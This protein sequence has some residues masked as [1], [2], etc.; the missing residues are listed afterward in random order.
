MQ[1]RC[2]QQLLEADAA[3][4]AAAAAGIPRQRGG[5]R[6]AVEEFRRDRQ[7]LRRRRVHLDHAARGPHQ[8]LA[9][10]ARRLLVGAWRCA[11]APAWSPPTSACRSRGWPI[12][13]SRPKRISK[14]LGLTAPIVGHVGDGNFHCSLLC[15]VNDAEEMARGEDFMR[16]LVERAQS[17]DGTCTGEHGIGQGKQKYLEGGTRDRGDRGDARGENGARSAQHLQPRQDR[18]AT[19]APFAEHFPRLAGAVSL[20]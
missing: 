11:P 3:G 5:G 2:L 9:G 7:G 19:L 16:R 12:A 18:P 17:M 10:A 15:D 20:P 14:R 8:T 6:G 13:W 1:V 4:D